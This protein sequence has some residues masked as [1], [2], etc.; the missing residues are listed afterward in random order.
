M[1]REEGKLVGKVYSS[2]ESQ[3]AALM[4]IDDRYCEEL[5]SITG[6]E[7]RHISP[8]SYI[9]IH[10]TIYGSE[11]ARRAIEIAKRAGFIVCGQ[12]PVRRRAQFPE[13]GE[14]M[15]IFFHVSAKRLAQDKRRR[16]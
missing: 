2:Y 13:I 11:R 6:M 7:V 15:I 4:R 10:G 14:Q 3:Q 9:E 12:V 16:T 8:K 1:K 5:E